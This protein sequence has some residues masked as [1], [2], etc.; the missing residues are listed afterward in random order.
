[1]LARKFYTCTDDVKIAL[2]RTY[3]TSFYTAHLWCKYTEV[4]M[5]KL[6]VE[7]NDALRILQSTWHY[8]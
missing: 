7:Y 4:K 5:K 1:M 3:C 2:F 8:K 6:Q